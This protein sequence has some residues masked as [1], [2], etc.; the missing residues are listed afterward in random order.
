MVNEL[1]NS[2]NNV[3]QLYTVCVIMLKTIIFWLNFVIFSYLEVRTHT[4]YLFIGFYS[5][6]WFAHLSNVCMHVNEI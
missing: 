3:N 4:S 2:T 6:T 5:K 1:D